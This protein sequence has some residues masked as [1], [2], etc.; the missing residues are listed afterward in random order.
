M[1]RAPKGLLFSIDRNARVGDTHDFRAQ[2]ESL[3]GDWFLFSKL[4]CL[5]KVQKENDHYVRMGCTSVFLLVL[6]VPY[7]L[8][9][10]IN[11]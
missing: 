6:A 11:V 1:A 7:L 2:L 5:E 8:G 4:L 9:H 10:L 3:L